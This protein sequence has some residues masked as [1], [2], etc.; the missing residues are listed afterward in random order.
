MADVAGSVVPS[1]LDQKG[2]TTIWWVP[3]IADPT[4]PTVAEI[5]AAGAYRLTYDFTADGFNYAGSQ[6]TVDDDRLT[7]AQPLQSLDVNK[8]TLDL[9]YVQSSDT[10]AAQQVLTSGTSGYFVVRQN[11]PDPQVITADD[12]VTPIPVTLGV[13]NLGPIDGNGKSTIVQKCAI[14]GVVGDPVAVVAGS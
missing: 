9:K 6:D 11:V 5:G 14:R 7:L 8:V 1:A 4:A 13:Q 12:L 10:H 2:N 3:T